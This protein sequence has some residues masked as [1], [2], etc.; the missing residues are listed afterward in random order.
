MGPIGRWVLPCDRA[1]GWLFTCAQRADK[2]RWLL[3]H[4]RGW[5]VAETPAYLQVVATQS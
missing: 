3:Q 1:P 2:A 4:G 5:Q